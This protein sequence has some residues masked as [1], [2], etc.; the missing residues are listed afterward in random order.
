MNAQLKHLYFT[1]TGQTT[2]PYG[3][4]A[5]AHGR[6]LEIFRTSNLHRFTERL[7]FTPPGTPRDMNPQWTRLEPL[8][9]TPVLIPDMRAAFDP[10]AE[11]MVVGIAN[12]Y[13][14]VAPHP[15]GV[16]QKTLNLF[17]KDLW[18][19]NVLTPTQEDC[20][21]A[22]ID[23]IVLEKFQNPAA[24]WK[25]WSLV[26]WSTPDELPPLWNDYLAFQNAL[27]TRAALLSSPSLNL[28]PIMLEQ[29]LW[30]GI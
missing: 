3:T 18:A 12:D 27:R 14:P 20:L 19:W 28:Q 9:A 26:Q 7:F 24:S 21:H 15:L 10:W 29:I 23:R 6:L 11:A 22:T 16:A 17:L 30:G 13:A 2:F 8:V 1:Q 4:G 25:N 5:S